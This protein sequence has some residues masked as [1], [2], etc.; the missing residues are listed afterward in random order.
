MTNLAQTNQSNRNLAIVQQLYA[1]FARHDIEAILPIL[2][3]DVEW[4]EPE[5]PFNPAGGTRY[6]HPGFLELVRI[7]REAED[8]LALE[9]KQFLL[10]A[11]SVAVVGH[12]RI[13]A[14]PTNKTYETDFVHLFTLSE[15]KI[16]RFQEFFDTYIAGEAFRH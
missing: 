12:A 5:N 13:L 7:G 6:G 9:P 16:V 11:S 10:D 1:A 3:P 4:G 15:S 14:K 2:S 8:I